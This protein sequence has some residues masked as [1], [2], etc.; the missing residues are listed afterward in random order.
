MRANL[1]AELKH[2]GSNAVYLDYAATTPV[3]PQV[4][5]AMNECLGIDGTFGNASSRSHGFGRDAEAV[6]ELARTQVAELI[7]ADPS[8]IVWTSGAT[9]A[10][11]LAIKGVAHAN[12][13]RGRHL[14]TSTI[15]HKA[16]LDSCKKL[17]TEGFDVTY[18]CPDTDG[19]ITPD[20]V[21][22]ALRNDTVLVSLMHVNNELGTITDI[23]AI[24]KIVRN[25]GVMFHV[26]AAQSTARLPLDVQLSSADLVS[27]SAH[28]MYGP[29]GVGA[30]YIRRSPI[31][32]IQAQIHGGGQERSLRAG[33]LPTHQIVGM[34]E[35]AALLR[36][37]LKPDSVLVKKLDRLFLRYLS[38]IDG[39]SLNGNQLHRVPGI[40]NVFFPCV[41]NESLMM[42][43]PDVALSSG[44]A[45]TSSHIEP[46]HVL[47]SLG[48]SDSVANCSVRFSFG[49]FTKEHDVHIAGARIVEQVSALRQLSSAWQSDLYDEGRTESAIHSPTADRH[50]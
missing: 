39:A 10:I 46:S 41:D 2:H 26:D 23:E 33:T 42:S 47:T 37:H 40:F 35:A 3:D 13:D 34:G 25:H 12:A 7:N 36:Q 31:V 5:L 6:V 15:E 1:D 28:K 30:L 45:C 24:G 19:L 27:L 4:I 20:R 21:E 11:N 16:V 14:V 43:V 17:S 50:D 8:D 49:R 32:Q 44:A 9:E 29:K 18:V 22:Q 48:L 38:E